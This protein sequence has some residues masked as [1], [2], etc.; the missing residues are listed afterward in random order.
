LGECAGEPREDAEVGVK[1][2]A[3]KATDAERCE[4][5]FMLESAE[6]ALDGSAA[7]VEVAEP[8]RPARDERVTTVSLDP[9]GPRPALAVGQRHFV[10]LRA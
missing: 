10:A 1:L 7:M 6:L 9:D 3:L 2:Y 5:V 8:L 4:A